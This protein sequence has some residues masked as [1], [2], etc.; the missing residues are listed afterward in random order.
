M[1]LSWWYQISQQQVHKINN[2]QLTFPIRSER[3]GRNNDF[4]KT[5]TSKI[6]EEFS[7]NTNK[8]KNAF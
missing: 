2:L 8:P 5:I 4:Q 6:S 3:E 1:K 7:T